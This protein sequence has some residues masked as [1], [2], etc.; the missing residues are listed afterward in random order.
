MKHQKN[1]DQEIIGLIQIVNSPQV[2]IDRLVYVKD[3]GEL[4]KKNK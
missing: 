2:I 4:K 1:Q 3:D